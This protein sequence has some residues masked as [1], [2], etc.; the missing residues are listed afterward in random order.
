MVPL[1]VHAGRS[2]NWVHLRQRPAAWVTGTFL[3]QPILRLISPKVE[4]W[5]YLWACGANKPS[6]TI[7]TAPIAEAYSP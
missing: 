3:E 4:S 1:D 5:N 2:G 7:V 6:S